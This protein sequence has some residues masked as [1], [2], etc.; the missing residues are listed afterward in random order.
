MALSVTPPS[1]NNDNQQSANK[2]TNIPNSLIE[3]EL[4][5]VPEINENP[6]KET[7]LPTSPLLPQA[8]TSLVSPPQSLGHQGP[9]APIEH[10]SGL[11]VAPP[12]PVKLNTAAPSRDL[13][14]D[15]L[16]LPRIDENENIIFNDASLN[17]NAYQGIGVLTAEDIINKDY[18]IHYERL[19][20]KIV[21]VK[22]WLQEIISEQGRTEDIGVARRERGFKLAEMKNVLD[23]LL[24]RY[25]S[26]ETVVRK[27]DASVLSS[28]VINEI[29][30]L[31]PLEPL[32]GDPRI[33]EIMVNGPFKVRIEVNGKL[34]T[35]KGVRFRNQEHLLETCQQILSPLGKT[36]DVAHPLEDGRLSDGS[37]I[38]V[39]HPVVG[40]GGPYLTIRRFPETVFSMRKLVEMG[41]MTEDMA[42]EIGNLV[43]HACSVIVSG[44]TGTGKLVSHDTLLPTPFGMSTMGEVKV[45]DMLLD[46]NSEPTCVTAKYS[47]KVPV[48]YELTLSDGTKITADED[49]NWFTSTRSARRAWSR[50]EMDPK[51]RDAK[52]TRYGTDVELA[53]VLK[54]YNERPEFV[55]PL[56]FGSINSRMVHVA[57]RVIKNKNMVEATT[58]GKDGK[59][60]YSSKELINE[61]LTHISRDNLDQRHKSELESIVT[62]KEI[63]ESLKVNNGKHNNHAIR[64][65]SKP[66]PYSTQD[67]LVSPYAFG[68]WLGD[69]YTAEG[70]V[71]GI[72]DEI[73]DN[74]VTEGNIIAKTSYDTG[75]HRNT[76]LRSDRYE[77]MKENLK[78][79]GVLGNK[80]IP[81]AYLYSSEEQRRAV[82]AG[83]LDTDGTVSK[84]TGSVQFAN[85]NK[86]IIDGF[87]QII[88]SLGYQSTVTSKMPTYMH[89]GEK[90]VG[91]RA[92]T[93]SFFT[94]DDVFGLSRKQAVHEVIRKTKQAGHRSDLRY[95]VDVQPVESVPMSCIT[96]DS[97]NSLYLVTDAFVVTHNTSMLNA[98]SGCIPDDERV[99]TIEDNLELRLHPDRDVVSMEARRSH[100]G[101]KGNVT[102]RDLVVNS[103][104][105]RPDRVVVGEV[106]DGS[107]YD[108]LQAMN[109][110]HEGSMTT[111]HANDAHGAIDRLVNLISEVGELDSNQALSLISNGV[112]IIVSIGRYED[113]S[114]RVDAISEIPSRVS[115][116]NGISSLSPITIFEFKQTGEDANGKIFGEYV[117][118]NELSESI[119]KKHRLDKKRRLS[120]EEIFN[121]SDQTPKN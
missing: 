3:E 2:P 48:A 37:R 41:S 113:G 72:D 121:L 71:C 99:V 19:E 1:A 28:L 85:S 46:E 98:L 17:L 63:F 76:P 110:G 54:F 81:D 36:I 45:G 100:Q 92:Y 12:A 106:R 16:H 65:I 96:V 68:A 35:A 51:H 27:E 61:V 60:L 78:A 97:P 66:V 103:L 49:H 87:R 114:R 95:I 38:N 47:L 8:P 75:A 22:E 14:E 58:R 62:T 109:T 4:G 9:P 53:S 73:F 119:T 120:L 86:A 26:Q 42:Q 77:G 84:V 64:M 79:L 117:K 18:S 82:I 25:F 23:Q 83:M 20:P 21:E 70:A 11:S 118:V 24:V 30:G 101:S 108:M 5:Y 43:Y 44:G 74:I 32:W 90:K 104:R 55:S 34:V 33:T 105:Q 57:R 89:N 50:Q 107:A 94:N 40:P 59:V 15:A 29:L 116:E 52:R 56:D 6:S 93:V 102:I 67:L 115:T 80:F 10:K 39:T 7:S 112:D 69:G 88:H 31:G 13:D 91:K 111:V